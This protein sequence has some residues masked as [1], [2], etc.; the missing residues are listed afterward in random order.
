[1]SQSND[2]GEVK[3]QFLTTTRIITFAL[4]AGLVFFGVIAFVIGSDKQPGDPLVAYMA[5]GFGIFSI[6]LQAVVPPMVVA[7]TRDQQLKPSIR[8]G[9]LEPSQATEKLC[10]LF[11]TKQIIRNALLEGA[12]F[13]C[14]V[15]YIISVQWWLYG[16]VC[17][18]IA[19]MIFTL[20]TRG[21]L[22]HWID[23]QMQL[24]E[25]SS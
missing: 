21:G 12:G 15:A 1:M 20:P 5:G 9:R 4:I 7:S 23:D 16:I 25:L 18:L 17:V 19:L 13:F 8:E 3:G 11:Q 2:F 14:L 10:A 22:D 24:L 6:V